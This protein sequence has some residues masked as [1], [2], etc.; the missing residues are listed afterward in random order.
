M[1]KTVILAG[2]LAALLSSGVFA[3][4]ATLEFQ[5]VD[6]VAPAA[7]DQTNFNLTVREN[8]T[9]WLVGD[10]QFSQTNNDGSQGLASS[11]VEAGLTPTYK[12]NQ[13]V[14]A[15]A[16]ETIGEKYTSTGH[17][18]Y[19]SA[20]PGIRVPVGTTGLTAQLGWRFRTAFDDAVQDTTRTWRAGVAYAVTPK[21]TV[22]V[23]YD[24]VQGNSDQRVM[25][26]NY[27]RGF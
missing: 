23:R 10:T 18:S 26:V 5:S 11:R 14:T 22:G 6:N 7:A 2:L 4:S 20:E 16:R 21:D 25:A 12:I 27:T 9:S 1:K 24:R 8:I 17:S 13:Y 15:Y 3:A 19:W